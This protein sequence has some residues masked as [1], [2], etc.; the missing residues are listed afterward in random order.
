MSEAYLHT[1]HCLDD[2]MQMSASLAASVG[3]VWHMHVNERGPPP[4]AV[5]PSLAAAA[6][7][8]LQ[9]YSVQSCQTN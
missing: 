9:Y 6:G 3:P 8:A 7:N 1:V 2:Y 4:A 5:Q